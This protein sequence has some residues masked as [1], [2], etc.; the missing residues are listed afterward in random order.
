M[1]EYLFIFVLTCLGWAAAKLINLIIDRSSKGDKA[2]SQVC[3]YCGRRIPVI[4]YFSVI[5][6]CPYCSAPYPKRVWLVDLSCVSTTL[7][8]GMIIVDARAFLLTWMVVAY[9]FTAMVIDL[10]KRMI[11][12][13]IN[14]YGTI[15]CAAA[16]VYL[17]GWK[18]T[19]SGGAAGFLVMFIIYYCGLL[20]FRYLS[21]K[22]VAGV[23]P[24]TI[25]FGDVFLCGNI[26]L[27]M[28]FPKIIP[29]IFLG[30]FLAGIVGL[31]IKLYQWILLNSRRT[32]LW[33]PMSPF[34]ILSAVIIEMLPK[35]F[36]L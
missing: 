34:F 13:Y 25:G 8:L 33:I 5:Y 6:A 1:D 15:L 12:H 26:G 14:I 10:E 3:P 36:P 17:S 30:I 18:V 21:P 16:G 32:I 31:S 35:A 9:L 19:L 28:G 23:F 20:Y 11:F 22:R 7:L 24:S 27:F 29:A 4:H 2:G